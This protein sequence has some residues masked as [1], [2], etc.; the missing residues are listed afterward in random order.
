[1]AKV[2]A[3][4]NQ[5]GGVGKTTTAVNLAASLAAAERRVL[6]V[7]ADPQANSSS[8]VGYPSGSVERTVYNALV[9]QCEL[10]EIVL[11]T[12][13]DYLWLVPANADL[14][15]AEVELPELEN[16]ALR[17]SEVLAPVR[18]QYDYIF[19]D[20]PPSLN[21]LTINALCAADS[22]LIPLQCEFYALEGLSRLI[23]TIER[24][25][26]SYNPR[27]AIEGIL[28]C[29]FDG[30]TNLSRE[31]AAE[32]RTHFPDK[33]YQTVIPRNVRLGESPS[34]GKPILL[35]DVESRGC[36][37]YLQLAQEVIDRGAAHAP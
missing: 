7:D 33:V 35:Y 22:V 26:G 6:L 11:S 15:G 1:M 23:D 31:V 3:I 16:H 29:M 20:C 12:E 8:G 32:V 34:F 18:G 25:R 4:A 2:V 21:A 28:F 36:Q 30:R 37:S 19:I 14:S 13:L 10:A 24:V 9:E 17:L 5:K 27:L